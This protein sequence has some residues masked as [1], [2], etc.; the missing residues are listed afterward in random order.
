[1]RMTSAG[2]TPLVLGLSLALPA[3]ASEPATHA[4]TLPTTPGQTVVVEWTGTALP[5]ASGQ[6]TNGNIADP[7]L[8]VPCPSPG[9]DDAHA[10]TLTVPAGAYD[11]GL[12]VNADFHIEWDG[13][14]TTQVDTGL[15][16]LKDPDLVLSVYQDSLTYSSSDGGEPEENVGLQNPADG[17]YTAVVCSFL[18]SSEVPY[19]GRLTLTAVAE[20][21]CLVDPRG[22]TLTN[23]PMA[24]GGA[25]I[26]RPDARGTPNLDLFS[27]ETRTLEREVPTHAAGR[28]QSVIFDQTLSLPTFLWARVDAPVAAVG[29]LEQRELLIEHAR[30]HLRSEAKQLRLS[31]QLIDEA[32]VADAQFN[33]DGPAIVRF[34]QRVNGLE[35]YHRA[36]SVMLDR[37]YRPVAVSGHFTPLTEPLA[38]NFAL[39]AEHAIAAAWTTLGGALDAGQLSL[40]ETRGD[41]Q[42]FRVADLEGSHVFER[43][44]RVRQLYYPRT[45]GLEPAYHVELFAKHRITGQ[46]VAYSMV[47]SARDGSLLARKDLK[48]DAA[49]SYRVFAENKGPVYPPFDSPLGNGYTPFPGANRNDRLKRNGAAT[50]LITLEHAGLSTGDPWLADDATTTTGNNVNACADKVDTPVSGLISNPANL[51]TA[52]VD[53]QPAMTGPASFDYPI[54]PDE[55]PANPNAQAA[56]VVNI[57]YMVNWLHDW[58][59]DHGFD[60]AS[61]N[62]QTRNYGRGGVEGDEILA[63]G[64]DASGRNNANMA[65]PSDG[66]SPTMQQYLFDGPLLGEVRQ[67]APTQ[68]PALTWTAIANGGDEDYDFEGTLELVNDG[69]GLSLSDGCGENIPYP[70]GFAELSP[71]GEPYTAFVS[72]VPQPSLSGKIAL[73][74]R[75]NCNTTFKIQYALLNGAIG[76]IVV[77]NVQGDPPTNIGNLDVPLAPEQPTEQVYA[78]TPTVIIRQDDG[79]ALKDLVASGQ[80]VR[81]HMTRTPSIDTDGTLDNQI[82][83]HEFFHYVHHRLTDS[84]SQQTGAMSEGWGDIDGFMLSVR[85]EDALVMGNDAWQGAYGLAGYVADNFWSGIRRAP[86]TTDFAKNAYTFRHI[87]EGEPTPDGGTGVGNAEVHSAGEIW[88][89]MMYE[90]YAGILTSRGV[91]G[92]AQT[93][94]KDYIIAGLKMTPA[95]ATYT[96]ARDAVLAA[97]MATDFGD[98]VACSKGFARRGAGLNAQSPARSSADLVG[99]VEDYT[100][101]VCPGA[102]NPRIPPRAAVAEG[103]SPVVGSLGLGLLL[104]LMGLAAWRRRRSR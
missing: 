47:M 46:L 20:L 37:S 73:V 1:M 34:R 81:V 44:P 60:E 42:R 103:T 32:A 89:N 25:T 64:Q 98:Y 76:V 4:V 55:N 62:A 54:E 12:R 51:C 39:G 22:Q 23:G 74:D 65:T 102:G 59:Y 70:E 30:A 68:G 75:G 3:M 11:S 24:P 63:Q 58:W 26:F 88:A 8:W 33:G 49:Y 17:T 15:L 41:W 101:F 83:A 84:T 45:N 79:D 71:V 38:D 91:F 2:V 93:R 86:Y 57:F 61:G 56:A 16:T 77:N 94:M 35:V 52:A 97:A 95:N 13:S 104:P 31:H 9:P 53:P 18:S 40:D 50:S 87:A 80:E 10:I 28:L 21:A 27:A 48:S 36:L 82:I 99:V 85:A 96:E 29:A 5:G 6:G 14:N 43:W 72:P 90:C 67:V 69:M 100:E 78:D 19:K 92:G 66:S 7:L